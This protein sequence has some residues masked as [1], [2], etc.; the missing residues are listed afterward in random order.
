[1]LVVAYHYKPTKIMFLPSISLISNDIEHLF[2]Y[3]LAILVCFLRGTFQVC[4]HISIE[5]SFSYQLLELLSIFLI[6]DLC[7]LC[8]LH[9]CNFL[10]YSLNVTEQSQWVRYPSR[11][12]K[13]NSEGTV[14]RREKRIYWSGSQTGKR[15]AR[16]RSVSSRQKPEVNLKD[17]V[18]KELSIFINF[19]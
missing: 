5:F 13:T 10:V 14:F 12:E 4:S 18:R 6:L 16:L 8:P 7:W 17:E 9:L 11:T 1:M 19:N 2:I 15:E 3:L